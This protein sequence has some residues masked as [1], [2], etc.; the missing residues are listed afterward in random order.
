MPA[1]GRRDFIRRLKIE[2]VVTEHN[3]CN[4]SV[5]VAVKYTIKSDAT[6]E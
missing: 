2:Y 6:M 5:V 1:N 4:F 3:C